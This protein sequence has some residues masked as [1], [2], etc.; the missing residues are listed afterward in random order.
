MVIHYEPYID[1]DCE[2]TPFCNTTS[3]EQTETSGNW[4]FVTCKKCLKLRK[5]AEMFV[6]ETEKHILND[7]QEFVNYIKK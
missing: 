1:T 6:K 3:S 4:N 5:K 7:M 2:P